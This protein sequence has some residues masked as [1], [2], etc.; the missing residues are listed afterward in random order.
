M[1][2]DGNTPNV[3]CPDRFDP[4]SQN[5]LQYFPDPNLPGDPFTNTNNYISQAGS[6][7]ITDSILFRLDHNLTD[8]QRIFGRF[9][10]D[11]QHFNPDNVLGNI[12]DF[13]ADPFLNRHRGLTLSYTNTMNPSTVLNIRYGLVREKQLNDSFSTGFDIT[14][15]GFP[16]SLKA[17]FELPVFPRFDIGGFTS[18]G[19]QFFSVVDRANTTQSLAAN[20]SKVIGRHSIEAGVDLRLI[21]GALFQAGW[22]SGQFTFDSGFT[23]GPDPFGGSGDGSG[24]ASFLLGTTGDGISAFDPHWYF[25]NK[26]YAFYIQDDIKVS[27]KLTLNIGL[28]YDYESPLEDRYDQLNFVDFESDTPI[29]VTP[30]DV[31]SGLG[32][33]PQLPLK[34]GAGFPGIGGLDKGVTLPQRKDFG[35]RF[36]LAYSI[37]DKTVIRTGY[38][39]I[40]PGSAADNSGNYPSIVGF[41]PITNMASAPDGITP[42]NRPDRG[43]LLSNPFPNGLNPFEGS[44]KGLLTALGDRLVGFS[45]HD[46]HAYYQQWNFGIQRELPGNMLVEAAYVGGHGVK[47]QDYAGSPFNALPDQYLALEDS[48]F[49]SLPNPFYGVLPASS[50]VGSSPTITREQLLRPYP[51]FTGVDEQAPHRSSSSYNGFQLKVQK[52]LSQGLSALVSYTASKLIDDVSASDGPNAFTLTHQN[53]NNFRLDRSV[54]ALDRSQ[55]LRVSS[56][57]EL[58]FG[59]GKPLGAGITT[60]VIGQIISGW[61]ISSIVSFATGFPVGMGCAVCV[62]PANRPDLIGDPNQGASGP[63]QSRLDRYF[64][65]DAFQVNTPFH[66]GTAPRVLPNTRGPGQAN[67]DISFIKNTQLGERSIQFRAEFFNAFNRPE[68]GQPDRNFGSGTFGQISYQANLPRQIQFALKFYW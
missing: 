36:G 17:Q 42:Y 7:Q 24:F 14:T 19:S 46:P 57:Y 21:Q 65:V 61:Q 12:A 35:P 58:P 27:P 45:R 68:F 1:G 2:C 25:T 54:S 55:I 20:L 10:L 28:R 43:F 39:I 52:R 23:N 63:A 4:V 40:Y 50:S 51:H 38:G 13:N 29:S 62:Y 37:N 49:E 33:R 3:I 60:P 53:Q 66:Y 11:R 18:L 34:A 15:L 26:Y 22:P 6:R 67:A 64:N 56:I 8:R 47:L 32:L 48:L 44:S 9:S 31:G 41:N 5:L 16:A 59:R 30:V